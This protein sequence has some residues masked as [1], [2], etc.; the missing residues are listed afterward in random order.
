MMIVFVVIMV[1]MMGVRK[2]MDN[3]PPPLILHQKHP[4][5]KSVHMIH[6]EMRTIGERGDQRATQIESDKVKEIRE[7]NL[8]SIRENYAGNWILF[9][10]DIE[11]FRSFDSLEDAQRVGIGYKVYCVE[12]WDV[13]RTKVIVRGENGDDDHEMIDNFL[14]EID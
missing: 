4:P 13:I 14:N 9:T 2:V 3:Q 12:M 6:S 11:G 10:S 5:K 7:R 8:D 1:V